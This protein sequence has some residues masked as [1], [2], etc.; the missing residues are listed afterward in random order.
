MNRPSHQGRQGAL[1]REA[2]HRLADTLA[3]YRVLT[4]HQL[5]KLSGEAHWRAAPFQEA[6]EWAVDHGVLRRLDAD[7]YK[8]TGL[9]AT[10]SRGERCV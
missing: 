9:E 1:V 5:A 6:R 3:P 4:R 2:A 7:S 10:I 8:T